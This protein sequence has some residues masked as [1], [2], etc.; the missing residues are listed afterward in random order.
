MHGDIY[1]RH[2]SREL[3]SSPSDCI[4]CPHTAILVEFVFVFETFL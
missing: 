2:I 4:V 1:K 3:W